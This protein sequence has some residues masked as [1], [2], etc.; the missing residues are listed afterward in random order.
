MSQNCHTSPSEEVSAHYHTDRYGN[1]YEV[2]L[3]AEN[4]VVF[5][6]TP[7]LGLDLKVYGLSAHRARELDTRSMIIFRKEP[8][9]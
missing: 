3:I 8:N 7:P 9:L 1:R 4:F 6:S 2:N 5:D